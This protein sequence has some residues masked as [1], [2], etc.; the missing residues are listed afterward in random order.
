MWWTKMLLFLSDGLQL[1]RLTWQCNKVY[2]WW[3]AERHISRLQA[4][5][6]TE[7]VLPTGS[8]WLLF[9]DLLLY[10]YLVSWRWLLLAHLT[11]CD[12]VKC[13]CSFQLYVTLINSFLHYITVCEASDS[14]QEVT[15]IYIQL[16]D[17]RLCTCSVTFEICICAQECISLTLQCTNIVGW[18]TRRASG[19]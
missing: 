11:R 16:L 18:V 14:G 4:K 2:V 17:N 15:C 1:P 12:C 6:A 10:S 8:W 5:A 19:L 13:P 3:P 7:N 9:S